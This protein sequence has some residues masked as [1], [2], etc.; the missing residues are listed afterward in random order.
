M[1]EIP[2]RYEPVPWSDLAQSTLE[3]A[4]KFDTVRGLDTIA[5]MRER[6]A[7]LFAVTLNGRPLMWYVLELNQHP[8]GTEAVIAAV[9]GRVSGIDL[10]TLLSSVVQV[11]VAGVADHI[12]F[13]TKRP[14]LVKKA[15]RLGWN[16]DAVMMRKTV[17]MQ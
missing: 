15:T 9:A 13:L 5:A 6:A 16:P 14:A 3:R 12:M 2:L 17:N 4:E 10:T 1:A 7:P 8:H 11:Q